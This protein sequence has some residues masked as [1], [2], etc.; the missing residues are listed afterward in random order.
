M[1]HLLIFFNS[2]FNKV[3]QRSVLD[4]SSVTGIGIEIG[5]SKACPFLAGEA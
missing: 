2:G 1:M 5:I 4:K 3:I